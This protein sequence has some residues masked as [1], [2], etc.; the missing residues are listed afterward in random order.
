MSE[1]QHNFPAG[2]QAAINLA[3][4]HAWYGKAHREA[5]SFGLP[6]KLLTWE[7]KQATGKALTP[8]QMLAVVEHHVD[9]ALELLHHADEM[10]DDLIASGAWAVQLAYLM[11]CSFGYNAPPRPKQ[12]LSWL[13]PTSPIPCT[14][15]V[16][17]RLGDQADCTD[18]Q[19]QGN[20]IK[21]QPD[22][23]VVVSQKHHKT[24][25]K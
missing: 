6:P 1:H 17:K 3:A 15:H 16:V 2:S 7:Q 5:G 25:A 14:G 9:A 13:L 24:E 19:S 23:S 21:P 4:L 11:L 22:G 8:Q 10:G 18:P 20:K 12:L